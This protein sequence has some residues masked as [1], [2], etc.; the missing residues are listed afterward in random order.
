MLISRRR[1]GDTQ[2][3]YFYEWEIIDVAPMTT[4][5][6]VMRTFRRYASISR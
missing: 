5:P 4:T 1:P 6:S 2:E 3:K